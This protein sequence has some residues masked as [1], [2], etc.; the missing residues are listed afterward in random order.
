MRTVYQFARTQLT[1]QSLAAVAMR[2]TAMP[3]QAFSGLGHVKTTLKSPGDNDIASSPRPHRSRGADDRWWISCFP[4]LLSMLLR[5]LAGGRAKI[6]QR[7]A[8]LVF[9]ILDDA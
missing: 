7:I 5:H 9:R 3:R 2:M 1:L 8:A 4:G 6:L